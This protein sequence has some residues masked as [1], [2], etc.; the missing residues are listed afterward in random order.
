MP[1][2]CVTVADTHALHHSVTYLHENSG[3]DPREM[4]STPA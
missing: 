4:R 2:L 3:L 1:I